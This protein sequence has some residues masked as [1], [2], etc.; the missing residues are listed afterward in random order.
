MTKEC[1]GKPMK[2]ERIT[3][4]T[5]GIAKERL[6]K[7]MK[8]HKNYQENLRNYKGTLR[9]TYEN[10]KNYKEDL[11]NYKRTLE[12]GLIFSVQIAYLGSTVLYL[13]LFPTTNLEIHANWAED[14]PLN[15][16]CQNNDE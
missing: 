13:R 5:S 10:T 4:T 11:R 12:H 8:T 2:A 9:K 15:N 1:V 3:R 14:I 6:G 16:V 7:P